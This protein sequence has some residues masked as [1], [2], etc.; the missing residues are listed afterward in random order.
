MNGAEQTW[1]YRAVDA[2]G[3]RV[4]GSAEAAHPRQLPRT[5]EA[6][7]LTLVTADPAASHAGALSAPG[8]G[9][10]HQVLEV[11]RALASLLPAGLPLAR[12]LRAATNLATGPVA[13]AL[14][15]VRIR[16]ERGESLADALSQHPG[17][18]SPLYVGVVRAGE[19]SGD[20]DAA[21]AR[22]A[23]QLERDERL[24]AKLLSASIY[25]TILLVLGGVAVLVLLLFVIPRFAQLLS[26]SGARLPTSTATLLSISEGATEKHISNIFGKLQLPDSEN[27]HRRVLAVLTY[28][29][30]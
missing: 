30:S 21:F 19:K 29:G 28:L 4:R 12:A 1:T 24:R 13:R 26:D 11:T 3:K 2:K 22:L 17:L 8:F 6:R 15:G 10:R 20:L 23:A 9:S 25:P 16:V 14:D 5:L 18:F 27:D 7:G